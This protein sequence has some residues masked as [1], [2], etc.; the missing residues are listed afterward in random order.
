MASSLYACCPPLP[1]P[2]RGFPLNISVDPTD[3]NRIAYPSGNN[4]ILRSLRDAADVFMYVGHAGRRVQ[5]VAI[6][7]NGQWVASGDISGAL[8]VWGAKGDH[9]HKGEFRLWSGEIRGISWSPDSQRIAACGSG[10]EVSAVCIMWDTGN[11]ASPE[12]GDMSGHQKAV[13]TIAFRPARPLRIATGSEDMCVNFYEGPPFKFKMSHTGKHSNFVQGTAFTPSGHLLLTCGSDGLV[14]AYEG[15]T[16]D[17]RYAFPK[18]PCTAFSLVCPDDD[19]VVVAYADKHVRCFHLGQEAATL[20]WDVEVGKNLGD[21]Q[22]GVAAAGKDAVIT[23]CLDGRLMRW[24]VSDGQLIEAIVGSSGKRSSVIWTSTDS[25]VHEWK[26]ENHEV[27]C[28]ARGIRPSAGVLYHNGSSGWPVMVDK[29]GTVLQ[30]M[31][32]LGQI[33]DASQLLGFSEGSPILFSAKGCR[34]ETADGK[35]TVQLPRDPLALAVGEDLRCFV[36]A[37]EASTSS[38][39]EQTTERVVHVYNSAGEQVRAIKSIH[40]A[41]VCLLRFSRDK[42]HLA[43][44]AVDGSV[45]VISTTDWATMPST[46]HWTFHTSR[47][48]SCDWLAAGSRLVTAGLDKTVCIF[49]LATANL[50]TR[51]FDCHKDGVTCVRWLD[52]G[53]LA[54]G[55]GD[56]FIRLWKI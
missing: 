23:T 39:H 10:R 29:A 14:N 54:T 28:I 38:L 7:P 53:T 8:M 52:D 32:R 49:D 42:K 1:T 56:G 4:I 37:Y 44:G 17:F 47:I 12:I 45:S 6:S 50:V 41:D 11:K 3:P 25:T 34:L 5:A 33:P 19:T 15:S 18:I 9:P 48:M 36:A 27:L 22:V 16:A 31:A 43:V 24:S 46:Q 20:T 40:K 51:I 21:Q 2:E 55:G 35:W 26:L 30:G 13:N